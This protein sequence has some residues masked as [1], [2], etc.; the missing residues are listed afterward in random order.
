MLLVLNMVVW[1]VD[2]VVSFWEWA[3]LCCSWNMKQRLVFKIFASMTDFWSL[4]SLISAT[5]SSRC[6]TLKGSMHVDAKG[7]TMLCETF[8]EACIHF[9]RMHTQWCMFLC[10]LLS[11]MLSSPW[12]NS[13]TLLPCNT[14]NMALKYSPRMLQPASW[15][16]HV[17][18]LAS[19]GMWPL[20]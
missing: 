14:E 6:V 11:I 19:T 15:Y 9:S 4:K 16:M 2:I 20:T 1:F 17:S 3:A 10:Q 18:P 7:N 5:I 13:G 12:W 8:C